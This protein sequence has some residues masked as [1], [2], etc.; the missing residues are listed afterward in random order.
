MDIYNTNSAI[1]V[2]LLESYI[3]AFAEN[4][5]KRK[6]RDRMWNRRWFP[7]SPLC[8][9]PLLSPSNIHPLPAPSLIL[10][11][12]PPD[13]PY[14]PPLD[15]EQ[16]QIR[17]LASANPPSHLRLFLSSE[18]KRK[19]KAHRLTQLSSAQLSNFMS[20]QI[21]S[22]LLS[23]RTRRLIGRAEADPCCS[24]SPPRRAG[25]E[26]VLLGRV[27]LLRYERTVRYYTVL[28][29]GG[30]KGTLWRPPLFMVG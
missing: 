21:R 29:G 2:E 24:S 12:T 8:S 30:V 10:P 19:K 7:L 1:F 26:L 17:P 5:S 9:A 22:S 11:R 3:C 16:T 4:E 13:L 14:L 27:F 25:R 15:R 28:S 23:S 18:R 20:H 6:R